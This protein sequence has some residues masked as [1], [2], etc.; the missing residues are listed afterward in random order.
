MTEIKVY[1]TTYP[2]GQ[3]MGAWL[4][5]KEATGKEA[6][7]I[8]PASP[9]ELTTFLWCTVRAACERHGREFDMTLSHFACGI[10]SEALTEWTAAMEAEAATD[11]SKKKTAKSR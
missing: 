3:T 5:F 9:S 1:N 6:S 2:C 10:D 8:D 11:K 7:A 4:F